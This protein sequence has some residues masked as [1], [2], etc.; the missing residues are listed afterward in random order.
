MGI[1][2]TP[3]PTSELLEQELID[4]AASGRPLCRHTCEAHNE[5]RTVDRGVGPAPHEV[6]CER[7]R[8]HEGAVALSEAHLGHDEGGNLTTFM[9]ACGEDGDG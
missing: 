2:R 4:A 7:L 8:D 5:G 3:Q 1:P 6:V 9:C